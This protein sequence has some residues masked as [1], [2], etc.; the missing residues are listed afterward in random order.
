MNAEER[1]DW[2]CLTISASLWVWLVFAAECIDVASQKP[3]QLSGRLDHRVFPGP[4]NYEDVQ[5]G[6]APESAYILELASPRCFIGDEFLEF[7]C[8]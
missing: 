6:D 5:K 2:R 8:S 4:P 7:I 1:M 3:I